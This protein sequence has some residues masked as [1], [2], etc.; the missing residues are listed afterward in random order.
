MQEEESI[1]NQCYKIN[2]EIMSLRL[3]LLI[4]KL[5]VLSLAFSLAITIVLLSKYPPVVLFVLYR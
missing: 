5:D 3:N 2:L 4:L 1:A